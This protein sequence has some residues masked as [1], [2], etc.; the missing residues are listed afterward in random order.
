MTDVVSGTNHGEEGQIRAIR[1]ETSPYN[2]NQKAKIQYG[3][4]LVNFSRV[5]QLTVRRE[6]MVSCVREAAL[7]NSG[8]VKALSGTTH[9]AFV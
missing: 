3:T 6:D 4:N 5:A 7:K 2:N 1:L 9:T 8:E